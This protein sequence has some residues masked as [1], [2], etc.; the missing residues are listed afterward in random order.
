MWTRW[1]C[2]VCN[3]TYEGAKPL[4]KCPRCGNEDPDKFGDAD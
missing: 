4:K 2:M 1:K 3:Y